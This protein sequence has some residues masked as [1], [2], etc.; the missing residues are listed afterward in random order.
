LN[1]DTSNKEEAKFNSDGLLPEIEDKRQLIKEE[2][3]KMLREKTIRP[4]LLA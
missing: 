4:S 3:L 1:N 2:D